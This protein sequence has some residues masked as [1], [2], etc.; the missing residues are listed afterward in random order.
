M[1]ANSFVDC[2]R[3][4][5]KNF[6]SKCLWRAYLV[7]PK[8]ILKWKKSNKYCSETYKY[9]Y[10]G[11]CSGFYDG[12]GKLTFHIVI[13]KTLDDKERTDALLHEFAHVLQ[14]QLPNTSGHDET[15]H[16]I[17]KKIL[18]KWNTRCT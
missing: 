3:W 10:E 5:R 6:K 18:R 17:H 1:S 9:E 14:L 8:T 2:K 16:K 11:L 13:L 7:T 12:D 4:I 15:F